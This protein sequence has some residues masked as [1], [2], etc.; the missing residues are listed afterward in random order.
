M[1]KHRSL[2]GYASLVFIF[3]FIVFSDTA[4]RSALNGIKLCGN[5]LV[6]TLF[7]MMVLTGIAIRSGIFN[8]FSRIGNK[9]FTPLFGIG[10]K[11]IA[12]FFIGILGSAPTGAMAVKNLS[13]EKE[14]DGEKASALLLS[15]VVSFGFIYSVVGINILGNSRRGIALFFFQIVSVMLTAAFL[16]TKKPRGVTVKKQ[17]IQTEKISTAVASSIRDAAT[18]MLSVCGSVIF[19]SS[20]SGMIVSLPIKENIK[21][22]VC[23]FLELA[24]G[25]QYISGRFSPDVTFILAS[26]AIGWSGLSMIFQSLA[27]SEGKILSYKY[28]LGRAVSA[29]ICLLLA[30][31]SINIG[32]I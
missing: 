26:S 16:R 1:V 32:I 14:S 13:G 5:V 15:S 3:F 6:P 20:L 11:Y 27:V 2:L 19:F 9:V 8:A 31:I 24:S 29:L 23:P 10:G 28:I 7:P 25:L 21:L 17:S 22:F 18:N 12:S 4:A 30:V